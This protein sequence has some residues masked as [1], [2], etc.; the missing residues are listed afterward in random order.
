MKIFLGTGI[1][2]FLF[3]IAGCEETDNRPAKSYLDSVNSEKYYTSEIIPY[4][5]QKIYD[6]WKLVDIS[7]GIHGGGYEPDFDFLEI[8]RIG[9]YGLIRNDSLF[10]YGKIELDTFD[11]ATID[12]LQ[13]KLVPDF[14]SS[15]N[16]YFHDPWKYID[17]KG[18]D[19]LNLFSP[20]CD[21]FDYHFNKNK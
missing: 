16:D 10:E 1:L 11:H 5:F 7:G 20:C 2:I 4:S 19:T 17:L 18:D 6:T 15:L 21:M 3:S 9:I 8:K 14:N 12:M 13:V